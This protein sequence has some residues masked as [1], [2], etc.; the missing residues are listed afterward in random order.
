MI[1]AD[2]NIYINSCNNPTEY[3]KNVF[4]KEDIAVCGVVRAEFLF[5]TVSVNTFC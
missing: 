1:L 3:F 4:V 2:T 5:G